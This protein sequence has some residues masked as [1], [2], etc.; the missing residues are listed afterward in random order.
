M[1]VTWNKKALTQLD[2]VMKYGRQEFGE[3]R[4]QAGTTK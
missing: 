2:A 4:A 3:P 1:Q